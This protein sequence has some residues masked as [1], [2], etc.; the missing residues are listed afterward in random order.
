[1]KKQAKTIK[2]YTAL[3]TGQSS[4]SVHPAKK[5]QLKLAKKTRIKIK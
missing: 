2:I 1:M 5:K 4:F 3:D